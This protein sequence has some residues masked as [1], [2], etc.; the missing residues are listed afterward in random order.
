[1]INKIR[2]KRLEKGWTQFEL[3]EKSGVPQSTISQ[4]ERGN[5]KYPTHENIM[6]IVKALE[7]TVEELVEE[8]LHGFEDLE[9]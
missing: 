6:K 5:R 9:Y 4:I 3:A 1:M 8:R 2:K 7:I